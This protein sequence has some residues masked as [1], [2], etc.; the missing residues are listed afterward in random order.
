M[1]INQS[2]RV[3]VSFIMCTDEDNI[4]E[5]YDKYF[6]KGII[7]VDIVDDYKSESRQIQ[8][9]Q[10]KKFRFTHGDYI[11]KLMLGSIDPNIDKLD[12]TS[13]NNCCIIS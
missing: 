10:G 1:R 12:E 9:V 11:V 5:A 8:K 4:V 6:D 2:G 3:H 13:L 7:N